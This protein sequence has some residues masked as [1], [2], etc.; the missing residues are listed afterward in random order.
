[1]PAKN[2]RL[3]KLWCGV[4]AMTSIMLVLVICHHWVNPWLAFDRNAILHGQI[5]RLATCHFVHLNLN[6]FLLDGS[7]FL[8]VT[9]VFQDVLSARLLAIWALV[10]APLCGLLLLLDPGLHG[11]VGL[12]GIL[13]GWLVIGLVIGFRTAPVLH[14]IALVLVAAKLLYEHTSLYNAGYLDGLI[15]GPVYPTAHL[16]GALVGLLIG[17]ASLMLRHRNWLTPPLP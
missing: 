1:M 13:H 3:R 2:M 14:S 4:I 9:L 11:Y 5:W 6:H 12:S 15:H 7:G 16:Y 10:S 8:L 17:L